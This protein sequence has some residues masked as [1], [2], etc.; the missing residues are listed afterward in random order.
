MGTLQQQFWD[1]VA[2]EEGIALDKKLEEGHISFEGYFIVNDILEIV[3]RRIAANE[4]LVFRFT[5]GNFNDFGLIK[6][7]LIGFV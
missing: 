2:Y 6:F 7:L 1:K 5:G 4:T 3:Y